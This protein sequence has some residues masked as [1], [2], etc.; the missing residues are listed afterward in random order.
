MSHELIQGYFTLTG[1]E[2]NAF[3]IFGKHN[4][5]NFILLIDTFDT[6]QGAKNAIKAAEILG[7]PADAVRIDSGNLA[8]LAKEVRK[9]DEKREKFRRIIATSD[10]TYELVDAII[11]AANPVDG[12]GVGT[13]MTAPSNP[14]AL[15][16]VYKLA[17]IESE[18]LNPTLK[19][20][21]D[22][23][24]TTFPGVK[25]IWRKIKNNKFVGDLIALE[26]EG[27]PGSDFKPLLAQ[28]IKRGKPLIEPRD[29]MDI[30]KS[31]GENIAKLPEIYAKTNNPEIYP[32]T[33]SEKLKKLRQE[34]I[35]EAKVA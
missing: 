19:I 24:K 6:I 27:S 13:R 2:I 22:A 28:A 11:G 26:D 16:G 10:L 21:E 35:R 34:L 9:L 8:N 17:A 33:I 23:E 20:S 5:D 15:G 3:V 4:P 25:N 7:M 12:F 18:R 31:A 30:Q 14:S 1:L 29:L 32:V